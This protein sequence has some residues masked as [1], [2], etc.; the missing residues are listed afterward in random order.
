[1][2]G[3]R[4]MYLAACECM[5]RRG[6]GKCLSPVYAPLPRA[7]TPSC[8]LAGV[9]WQRGGGVRAGGGVDYPKIKVFFKVPCCNGKR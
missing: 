4:G 2:A 5:G 7:P 6:C 8:V 3:R 1:V 9:L